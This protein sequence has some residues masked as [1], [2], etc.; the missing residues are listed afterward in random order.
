MTRSQ[1]SRRK[2][3]AIIRN[4]QMNWLGKY[5]NVNSEKQNTIV[6]YQPKTSKSKKKTNKLTESKKLSK[7]VN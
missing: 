4:L 6:F 5:K 3:S 1:L 7:N 2:K